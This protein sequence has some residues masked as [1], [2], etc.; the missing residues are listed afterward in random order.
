MIERVVQLSKA[1]GTG[2]FDSAVVI[3]ETNYTRAHIV[4]AS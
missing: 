2:C 4:K 1:G 3:P